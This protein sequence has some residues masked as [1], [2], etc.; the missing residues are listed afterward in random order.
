MLKKTENGMMEVGKQIFLERRACFFTFSAAGGVVQGWW[1]SIKV[2]W[3]L[4]R[5]PPHPVEPV[6]MGPLEP[7]A[8]PVVKVTD[9][10]WRTHPRMRRGHSCHWAHLNVHLTAAGFVL[11]VETV[12]GE[13]AHLALPDALVVAAGKPGA[14]A[15]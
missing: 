15:G 14:G 4:S 8:G 1:V 6:A 13:V 10:G 11:S 12:R 2:R 7:A 5:S 9:S 3:Y